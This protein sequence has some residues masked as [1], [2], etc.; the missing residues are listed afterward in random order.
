MTDC[1]H[2]FPFAGAGCLFL[3]SSEL[4]FP[5]HKIHVKKIILPIFFFYLSSTPSGI[6]GSLPCMPIAW[7]RG[8]IAVTVF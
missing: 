6:N 8:H 4:C 1:V 2:L 3:H 7:Y 5:C